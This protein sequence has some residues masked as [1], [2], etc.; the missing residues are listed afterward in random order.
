MQTIII[1]TCIIFAKKLALARELLVCL[2]FSPKIVYLCVSCKIV[3]QFANFLV[4]KLDKQKVIF[5]QNNNNNDYKNFCLRIMIAEKKLVNCEN[6]Q[7]VYAIYAPRDRY[8]GN[9][10]RLRRLILEIF[11]LVIPI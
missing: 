4:I 2:N 11:R 9:R 8:L 10:K 6:F 3:G 1:Y 5:F 7:K